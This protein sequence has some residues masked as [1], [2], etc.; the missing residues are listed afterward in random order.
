MYCSKCGK[1]NEPGAKFCTECGSPLENGSGNINAG[2]LLEQ[3]TRQS[4]GNAC[5]ARA[6]R[7]VK[8]RNC[9]DTDGDSNG[10]KTK[11]KKLIIAVVI[12]LIAALAA[13]GVIGGGHFYKA[14]QWQQYYDSGQKYLSEENYDEAVTAFTKAIKIDA[15]KPLAY[16]GRGDA[17]TG[18]AEMSSDTKKAV[19]LYKKAADDYSKAKKLGEKSAESKYNDTQQKIKQAENGVEIET[20][21]AN[22]NSGGRIALDGDG[23]YAADLEETTDMTVLPKECGYSASYD[24]QTDRSYKVGSNEFFLSKYELNAIKSSDSSII[25]RDAVSRRENIIVCGEW[26][27]YLSHT[28]ERN[29]D[30]VR[31]YDV[32]G[33]INYML[34]SIVTRIKKD[35]TARE[36]LKGCFASKFIIY[37]N[38]IFF[39]EDGDLLSYCKASDEAG[40]IYECDLDGQ[41]RKTLVDFNNDINKRSDKCFISNMLI[42]GNKLYFSAHI[43]DGGTLDYTLV[44]A[45]NEESGI[46]EVDINGENCKQ[47]VSKVSVYEFSVYRD[48]IYYYTYELDPSFHDSDVGYNHF[49]ETDLNGNVLYDYMNEDVSAIVPYDGNIY[50]IYGDVDIYKIGKW[51]AGSISCIKDLS[52]E[53]LNGTYAMA[54]DRSGIYYAADNVWK[55]I[56]IDGTDSENQSDTEKQPDT[57]W[58]AKYIN[59]VNEYNDDDTTYSLIDIDDNAVPELYVNVGS[60]PAGSKLISYVNGNVIE[61]EIHTDGLSYIEGKN[62][63]KDTGGRKYEGNLYIISYDDIYEIK[64]GKFDLISSG[65]YGG[66]IQDNG[67]GNEYYYFWNDKKL[68]SESEYDECINSVFN[69]KEAITPKGS[70]YDQIIQQVNSY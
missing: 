50:M 15:K 49:V 61:Q 34:K 1:E 5:N 65:G 56:N 25:T 41:N 16:I 21:C 9:S 53:A 28:D 3:E 68:N 19:E 20:I 23:Y 31:G 57:G 17:Y 36:E 22:V 48:S 46:Y 26:I 4:A 18:Q 38:K 55:H 13:A 60:T 52:N 59:C 35:G 42:K 44:D 63:F 12:V 29:K 40:Y 70:S 27:Y 37:D 30:A 6:G 66:E 64:D 58:K 24:S 8:V 69:E 54:F 14:H 11:H 45:A 10:K 67:Y 51:N 62:L 43:S 39:T 7:I 33:S 47:I 32:G 2:A